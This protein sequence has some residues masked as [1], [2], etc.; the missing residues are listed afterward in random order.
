LKRKIFLG[1]ISRYPLQ[2]LILK[3]QDSGL[4]TSIGAKALLLSFLFVANIQAFSQFPRPVG[5]EGSNAIFRD[6]S[7]FVG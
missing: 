4:S 5:T 3:N 2:V 1:A 6:S 7:V